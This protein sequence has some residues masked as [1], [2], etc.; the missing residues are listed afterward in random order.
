MYYGAVSDFFAQA[1]ISF[2][3]GHRN[4]AVFG[5]FLQNLQSSDAS[6]LT[7]LSRVRDAAVETSS[8]RVLSD[9]ESRLA[10]WTLLSP[11][12]RDVKL[13]PKLEEKVLLLVGERQTCLT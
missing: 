11:E 13:T 9:G 2:F 5:E 4:L 12:E 10:G 1:V 7:R 3:L 6:D 8:A